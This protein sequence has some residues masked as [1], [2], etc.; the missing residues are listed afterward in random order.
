MGAIEAGY[1]L[2]CLPLEVGDLFAEWLEIHFPDK[3]NHV[4]SLM[5]TV[6][7]GNLYDSRFGLRVVGSGPYAWMLGRRFEAATKR[8]GLTRSRVQLRCDLFRPPA[9]QGEQLCLL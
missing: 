3:L 7:G 9:Q 2:L 1:V 5:R 8:L 4:M 6:R